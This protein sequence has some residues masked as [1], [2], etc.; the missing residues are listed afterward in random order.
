[1]ID[2]LQLVIFDMDGLMFDTEREYCNAAQEIFDKHNIQV[3][4]QALY[5]IIGTSYPIDI[6]KFNLSEY[7]DETVLKLIDQSYIEK[8]DEMI[9]HGM[10]VKKGLYELLD[11]LQKNDIHMCVATSTPR[12]W[13]IQFLKTAKIYDYFDFIITGEEV[14]H[15]KPEPDIFLAAAHRANIPHENALVLEDSINGCKAAKKAQIPFI[16]IPDIKAPTQDI[17]HSAYAVL[18]DLSCV[19]E[20]I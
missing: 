20:M 7:P 8:I 6:K 18:D 1:M 16:M 15:G 3:N 5:D 13:A 4:M 2:H 10:P 9:Q 11:K 17:I 12:K 14:E 19:A